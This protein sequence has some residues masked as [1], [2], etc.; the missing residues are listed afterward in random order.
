MT[1]KPYLIVS[2]TPLSLS[3][4]SRTLK[5]ASSLSRFGYVS[6]VIENRPSRSPESYRP[7]KLGVLGWFHGGSN[8]SGPKNQAILGS[9][10][11][12]RE[13]SVARIRAALRPLI[14]RSIRE[15]LHLFSFAFAYL[16]MRPVQGLIQVPSASLYYLHEYRL[17][18]LLWLLNR[19]RGETPFIYDAHDV[20][21][22]VYAEKSL[23]PFWKKN[24]MGFLSRMEK[25]CVSNADVVVTVSDGCADLFEKLYGLRPHVIRNCHDRR[26]EKPVD[27]TLREQLDLTDQDFLIVVIGNRKPG[28]AIE[29]MLKALSDVPKRVHVAF[30]GRFHEETAALAV[31]LGVTSRVHTPGTVEP[32]QI[33]PFVRT[34][35][36]AALLYFAETENVHSILPNGFFQSLSAELPLLYPDLPDIVKVISSRHVGKKINPQDSKSL[37]REINSMLD[38]KEEMEVFSQELK[39]L[40]DEVSWEREEEKLQSLVSQ[41]II[42]T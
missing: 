3:R 6:W 13:D 34:A 31:E 39:L 40:A 41:S 37:I 16:F 17:F 32:E 9:D 14:S 7:V 2:L 10:Q 27:R 18:P 24:F 15:R 5:I 11:P 30:L 22:K 33:V 1:D 21:M 29:P 20:Y 42:E 4:D 38:N 26:L 25:W 19:V 35:D 28:Q 12:S 23:S 36:A 8:D